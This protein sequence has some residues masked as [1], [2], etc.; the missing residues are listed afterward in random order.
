M[1]VHHDIAAVNC[2]PMGTPV[3]V[4]RPSAASTASTASTATASGSKTPRIGGQ[5]SGSSTSNAKKGKGK[6][7]AGSAT[8]TVNRN[9]T[10]AG[11]LD[12]LAD[13]SAE[14]QHKKQKAQSF[15][16]NARR[17]SR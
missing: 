12:L 14:Q 2:R 15:D 16:P 17:S 8:S 3:V 6:R 13:S 4:L 10:P 9:S 5:G 1:L 11:G 7:S